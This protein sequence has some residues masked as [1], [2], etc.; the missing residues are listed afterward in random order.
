[1]K[2]RVREEG[3]IA[4]VVFEGDI[5]LEFSGDVREILLDN[6]SKARRVLVD[7]SGVTLI[8]SSGVASLLE[9][10]QTAR[11]RGKEFSLVAVGDPVMRV[12][13]LARL[14]TVFETAESIA[15]AMGDPA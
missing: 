2:Y 3:D 11:K 8:D 5:D 13:K 15:A 4:I 7:M 14:D 12:L 6:V 1:M 9:G 10:F